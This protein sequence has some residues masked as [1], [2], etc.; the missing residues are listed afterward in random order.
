MKDKCVSGLLVVDNDRPSGITSLRN[1]K[2][3]A[4]N[5]GSA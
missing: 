1:F 5:G 2:E 4:K 3:C